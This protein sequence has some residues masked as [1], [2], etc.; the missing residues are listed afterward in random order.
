MDCIYQSRLIFYMSRQFITKYFPFNRNL[1]GGTGPCPLWNFSKIFF[2]APA[3]AP[4]EYFSPRPRASSGG[5]RCSRAFSGLL[6]ELKTRLESPCTRVEAMG[7]SLIVQY[8]LSTC[9]ISWAKNLDIVSLI[10]SKIKKNKS[11][12]AFRNLNRK[13]KQKKLFI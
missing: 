5:A 4:F 13:T 2:R 3:V 9:K 10:K 6:R 11:S 1:K 7:S 12:Y 8:N